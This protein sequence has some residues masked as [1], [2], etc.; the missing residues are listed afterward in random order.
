[1]KLENI[2]LTSKS[3]E[4]IVKLADF[5]LSKFL[6]AQSVMNTICGT[7]MYIAPEVLLSKNFKYKYDFRADVWSLGVALYIWLVYTNR[8]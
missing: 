2:L 6:D 5:G 7:P 4:T 3:R 8:I 1:M